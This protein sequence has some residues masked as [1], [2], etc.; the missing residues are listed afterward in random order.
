MDAFIYRRIS[1]TEERQDID[2]QL[3]PLYRYCDENNLRVIAD[4]KDSVSGSVDVNKRNGYSRMLKEVEKLPNKKNLNIVFDEISRLGRTKKI[5]NNAIEYFTNQGINVHFLSPRCKMLDQNGKIIEM[6]DMII[7]IFA[8]LAE[9]ELN[10]IKYRTVTSVPRTAAKG[11][12]LGGYFALGYTTDENGKIIIHKSESEL[13]KLI[14]EMYTKVGAVKVANFLNQNEYK[15]KMGRK[16]EPTTILKI[17]Q[18]RNYLG[19][20]LVM[21]EMYKIDPIIDKDL[22]DKANKRRIEKRNYRS[23]S[24]VNVNPFVGIAKCGCGSKLRVRK[25]PDRTKVGKLSYVCQDSNNG[26]KKC[27]NFSTIDYNLLCNSVVSFFE[28]IIGDYSGDNE[29]IEQLNQELILKQSEYNK[30][31][32]SI[33][34]VQDSEDDLYYEKMR[35]NIDEARFNRLL[36]RLLDANKKDIKKEKSLKRNISDI[37]EKIEIFESKKNLNSINDIYDLKFFSQKFL[38]NITINTVNRKTLPN[39]DEHFKDRRNVIYEIQME[40]N[41]GLTI[42]FFTG[43]L[44]RVIYWKAFNRNKKESYDELLKSLRSGWH[45]G[46]V[47]ELIEE[48]KTKDVFIVRKNVDIFDVRHGNHY[49]AGKEADIEQN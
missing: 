48:P 5:I 10:R 45:G 38:K 3:K 46:T 17:I 27:N 4:F 26:V 11:H 28:K 34:S 21:G 12:S 1:T 7:T 23:H 18:N 35:G 30:V 8:Q 43:S 31:T 25:K 42:H 15:T 32:K 37:K 20:R 13:V 41:T 22:F 9:S 24:R 33:L 39:A 19:E 16:F 29:K 14:F 44:S 40:S 47:K 49:S 2:R 6:A 36:K